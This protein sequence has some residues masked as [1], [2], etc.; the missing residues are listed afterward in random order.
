MGKA[1]RLGNDLYTGRKSYDFIGRRPLWYAITGTIVLLAF[2]ALF[3]K[4]LNFGIEFTG[5]TEYRVPTQS[6]T[7]GLA[8]EVRDAV[9]DSEV[10]GTESATVTTA[11]SAVLV[12]V[13]ELTQDQS[14]QVLDAIAR[15]RN[16]AVKLRD[17]KGWDFGGH[18]WHDA[19][20]MPKGRPYGLT[21]RILLHQRL[22]RPILIGPRDPCRE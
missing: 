10:P 14:D 3:I 19:G 21:S 15:S 9:V 8:E 13:E 16:H 6:A 2:A 7:Q 18:A 17:P 4:G 22:G 12:Q 1:S 20:V 5:G 11:G